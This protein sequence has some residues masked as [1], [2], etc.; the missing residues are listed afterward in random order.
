MGKL[1]TAL[2]KGAKHGL[3][4]AAAAVGAAITT[5]T[6][7]SHLPLIALYGFLAGIGINIQAIKNS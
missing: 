4:T 1:S 6:E 2:W 5:G 3:T 7:P